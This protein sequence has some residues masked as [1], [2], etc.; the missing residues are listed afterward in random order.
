[1][2]R[3]AHGRVAFVTAAIA[4]ATVAVDSS[5]LASRLASPAVPISVAVE[6]HL[7]KETP[8]A[9]AR[10]AAERD[11]ALKA[12]FDRRATAVLHRD[13]AAFL[14]LI[15]PEQR[16]Y[17]TEQ[18]VVFDSIGKVGFSDWSY[19]L[20]PGESYSPGSIDYAKYAGA[21]DVWLP[22]LT[23]RYR[24]KGFDKLDVGRRVVY[25]VVRR[26][27][28]WY[29]GSDADL[30]KQTSS[31]TSVRVDPWENG[32]VV[33]ERSPHAMV[34]GHPDD[35]AAVDSI[36]AG[37]EA[38]VK[39]VVRYAGTRWS[40]K[41][42][43]ELPANDDETQRILE[44][45]QTFFDFAAIAHPLFTKPGDDADAEIAGA[46]VVINP[47]GFQPGSAFTK[48]LL[49]HE[50]THVAL[51][52]RTGPLSPKWLVEGIA[53]YVGNAESSLSVDRLA[54]SLV[55]V[56]ARSGPPSVLPSDSDFGLIDDAGSAYASSW[57]VCRYIVSRYG[58]AALFRLYDEMGSIE[59]ISHPGDKLGTSLRKV[60][61]T[62]E[63][64]LLRGWRPYVRSAVGD[65]GKLLPPPPAPWREGSRGEASVEDLAA[66]RKLSEK[67]LTGMG[68]ERG[69]EG[70][71]LRGGTPSAPENAIIEAVVVDRDEAGA[72]A[73]ERAFGGRLTPYDRGTPIPHGR[74]YLVALTMGGRE[75]NAAVAVLRAGNVVIEVRAVS[76]SGTLT[77]DAQRQAEAL[78]A[79]V[80]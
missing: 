70:I 20:M 3:L 62:S 73:A 50:I 2:S 32:P 5:V 27:K 4:L 44:N 26:G 49:R 56:V 17:R 54:G 53:E 61:H 66:E 72:A 18:D 43:I 57:L 8:K 39:H 51:F 1:M 65:L 80:A 34:I 78:Y 58:R 13:R 75:Y 59:G 16:D 21:D 12:L 42:V 31:G 64:G 29:V 79:A 68:V 19:E 77:A 38:A 67:A 40:R 30:D 23:L 52:D 6:R 74:L 22:V 55:P 9:A 11:T 48:T 7:L 25:T 63:D 37:V 46:R 45:P 35:S 33:V 36:L 28:R 47:D 71:W 76:R 24:I 14:A 10:R 60:L 69:G 15:D 41:V